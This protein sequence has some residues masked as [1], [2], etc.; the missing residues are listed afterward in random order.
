M[1][2]QGSLTGMLWDTMPTLY[3]NEDCP[4]QIQ[5]L[6][7]ALLGGSVGVVISYIVFELNRY[8]FRE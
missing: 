2:M 4:I 1:V 5:I 8:F 7:T 6:F 3:F